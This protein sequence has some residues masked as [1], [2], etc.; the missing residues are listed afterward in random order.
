MPMRSAQPPAATIAHHAAAVAF[1]LFLFSVEAWAQAGHLGAQLENLNVRTRTPHYALA[2]TVSDKT[3][4]QY[5]QALEFIYREY[6]AGFGELVK[7]EAPASQPQT[8]TKKPAGK[9]GQ[10]RKSRPQGQTEPPQDPNDGP[11]QTLDQDDPAG[12]F[13]VLIFGTDEEYQ[14]FGRQFLAGNTEHTDGMFIGRLN[15]LL[16]RDHGNIDDTR[17]TLFHEAFHQFMHRYVAN[18]PTW[19]NEGLAMYYGS[20]VPTRTGLKFSDPPG[21]Y[22]KLVR[23]LIEKEQTIPL[24]Q[25]VNASQA[26]FYDATP[27][28]VRGFD[29]VTRRHAYYAEAYTLVHTLLAD[30]SGRQRIRN[31]VRDLAKAD[32]KD[33]AKITQ[34]YFGPDTCAHMTPFWIK[35]VQSRVENQ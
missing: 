13:R 7:S 2:G 31:Y 25:L 5:G 6:A 21:G 19:L 11:A 12:R 33:A 29:D 26:E 24:V 17:S 1:V 14:S 23:K 15:L 20:A 16:I 30:A 22:W 4:Q 18:P 27:I 34:Q 8:S 35:H 3:L 32:G 28:H 9:A 10:G